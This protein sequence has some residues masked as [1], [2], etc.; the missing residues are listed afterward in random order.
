[1]TECVK[2]QGCGEGSIERM[3]TRISEKE[4]KRTSFDEMRVVSLCEA[5][6]ISGICDE[7][8]KM[9]RSCREKTMRMKDSKGWGEEDL[10]VMDYVCCFEM[11]QHVYERVECLMM[12]GLREEIEKNKYLLKGLIE[13]FRRLKKKKYEVIY[14][15]IKRELGWDVGD[16]VRIDFFIHG[17]CDMYEGMKYL[18]DDCGAIFG[19]GIVIRD[20]WGYDVSEFCEG[21]GGGESVVIITPGMRVEV[22]KVISGDVKTIEMG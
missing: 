17:S 22:K 2:Q 15:G 16:E 13:G 3:G 11:Y 12:I 1:M 9:S 6:R 18:E 14:G 20:V 5:L 4:K 8:N 21:D 19:T 7:G 10:E